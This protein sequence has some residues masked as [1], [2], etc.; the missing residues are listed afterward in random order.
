MATRQKGNG[1]QRRP[2]RPGQRPSGR[3]PQRA[4]GQPPKR[5]AQ[6]QRPQL[7]GVA[8]RSDEEEDYIRRPNRVA[9][10]SKQSARASGGH[11]AHRAHQQPKRPAAKRPAASQASSP[12]RITKKPTRKAKRQTLAALNAATSS[13]KPKTTG[14]FKRFLWRTFRFSMYWSVVLGI[15]GIVIVGGILAYYAAHLPPASE[16]AVPQRPPNVRIVS[17]NGTLI[18]NRGDT[19]GEAVRLEQLPDYLPKAVMAIEDRRFRYH[20]G[21]DPIG[22]VRAAITNYTN[23]RTVQGGSTL[24]QQLAKNLFLK[25]ERTM[26]RKMQEVVMALWLEWNYSKDEI[27]EMYLNRVYLG[28][29]AYGVDAASRVYFGKSAHLINLAEAATIAGLLKAPSKYA[30]TRNAARAEGRAQVVIAAMHQAGFIT[31]DDAKNA[32]F[33]PAHVV[34]SHN[35]SSG[36]YVADYVMELLP[37]Y[38]GS[39]REDII[40]DTTIDWD[41]QK[42]AETALISRISEAGR[43]LNVAQG[44]VVTLNRNGAIRALVGGVDYR[45]SQFNRA[46]YARRQPGSAFKP[47]VYLAALER[48]MSPTTIRK[49]GPVSYRGWKPKNYTKRYY[50][51]VTLTQALAYSINTVAAKLAHEVGPANVARTARRLGITS[52]LKSNPSI[53]LGTS[54]VTPLEIAAAYVPFSN[55]GYGVVPHIV[56]QIRNEKG[57]VLYRRSGDGTGRVIRGDKLSEINTMM[58]QTIYSGTG[59]RALMAGRPAGGK[60]GT[61]QGYK[62]AWFIG[63]TNSLTTA[64]WLGNDNN[65]PM[66]KVSGGTLP[67][68]IWA[69]V[70]E[71]QHQNIPIARL[72]GVPINLAETSPLQKPGTVRVRRQPALVA[73]PQKPQIAQPAVQATSAPPQK[74]NSTS[75]LNLLGR[76]FGGG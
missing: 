63:Y 27:L 45:K 12:K 32:L 4:E 13:G 31:A 73:A 3:P 74:E 1:K 23:G 61:T 9:A 72:P 10:T 21:I 6:P 76:L 62:D 19:G 71:T 58:A 30:P 64:V 34:S 57:E 53:A 44:A 22:L 42:A 67:A 55:G 29:G 75:P 65:K 2:M 25:P 69:W 46:V 56:R 33:N 11:D 8:L 20:F 66:K 15:W 48:G 68:E 38:A 40:V 35:S 59:K 41:M 60:T 24:T 43:E 52:A 7:Q 5:P 17:A 39:I 70:M 28:A 49:D 51:D 26:Q 18:A 14:R 16:W 54:E 47:F 37:G 50:G 36:N